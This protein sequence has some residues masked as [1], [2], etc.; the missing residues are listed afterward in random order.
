MN[1]RVARALIWINKIEDW[2]LIIMLAVMVLLAVAQIIYRNF[3]DSGVAWIDPS[4]RILVL[5]VALSGAVIA[6]RTDNHIRID[7]FTRYMSAA[8]CKLIQRAVY[9][10][11]VVVCIFISWHAFRFVQMEYEYGTEAFTGMKAWVTQL[12]IPG[13]FFMMAVRYL[14]LFISPPKVR[15]R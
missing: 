2:F 11:S 14:M 6:T 13:G 9:A 15:K 12:V 7:F 3:F 5:W 10:F 1:R 8:A 4:L